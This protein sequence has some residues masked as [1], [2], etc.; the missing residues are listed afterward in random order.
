MTKP[1][2]T[3]HRLDPLLKPRSIAL[4]GA[5][6]RPQSAGR[7]MVEMCCIDGFAGDVYLVNPKYQEISGRQCYASL[8]DLPETVDHVVLGLANMQLDAGLEDA[9]A[10]GTRAVT[11]FASCVSGSEDE[12]GL[13][14]MLQARASEAGIAICGG[15]S[16]GFYNRTIGLRVAAF[17]SAPG[18]NVGGVVW[19]AQSGSAF[20]ALAHNDRRL[21]FSL[22]VSSGMELTVTVA[23]YI[24]W[25]LAEPHTRVIGLFLEGVRDPERFSSV[26]ERA[27]ALGVPVVALKVGR[28]EV[29]AAMA[30]THTGA[31]AGSDAAWRALFR[32][33]NVVMVDDLDEMA[34][35]L[36]LLEQPRPI[37]PGALASLHDSGGERE[38]VVDVGSSLGVPFAAI[39]DH[40]RATLGQHLEPG[41]KPENPL[42]AW[43]TDAN[44]VD[45]Y[46]ACLV[47]LS[48]DPST[49][50]TM[51]F[52]D[53]RDNYWYSDGVIEAA[54][55]AARQTTKPIAVASNYALAR[56]AELAVSLREDGVPLLVGTRAALL[57]ARRVFI[58]RDR[59][60]Q[61]LKAHS[62]IPSPP[63][64]TVDHWRQRLTRAEALLETEAFALLSDYG[65]AVPP[66]RLAANPSEVLAAGAVIGFPVA[67]KSAAGHQHKSEIGGVTLDIRDSETLA[68]AYDDMSSR[69]GPDVMIAQMVPS[70]VEIALGALDDRQFGPIVMVA[71]GG[72]LIELVARSTVALAPF[73][74][75]EAD[76]LIDEL[77]L[78]RLLAGWRGAV[79]PSGLRSSLRSLASAAL[80]PISPEPT[81]RS[82]S[83]Q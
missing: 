33:H 63:T 75:E 74:M 55:N 44:Y 40:T 71:A 51:L 37:G 35:M 56:N 4:L 49:S 18:L 5:S 8:A 34:A 64:A 41:L 31:I 14:R 79:P 50:L 77:P 43:G 24:D 38:L 12:S 16:M 78:A 42:D 54:R 83:I 67:M 80:R 39:S 82:T 72:T 73:G 13:A 76:A 69:L 20:S 15:S 81:R 29:S 21:G 17:L 23:D 26:L 66:H 36:Q 11:I 60:E 2:V 52:S 3:S 22:C 47:A 59:Q 19:I 45:R 58:R 70:G 6:A 25:A 68:A 53:P 7:A 48:E 28:S 61:R 10:H 27:A 65:I 1:L 57:A 30:M 32:R 46:A 9:I 62:A